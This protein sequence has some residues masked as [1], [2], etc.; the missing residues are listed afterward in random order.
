M[1]MK[2]FILILFIANKSYFLRLHNRIGNEARGWFNMNT[3]IKSYI[4]SDK[5]D[6]DVTYISYYWICNNRN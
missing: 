4:S 6:V 5:K 2:H 3:K 1:E